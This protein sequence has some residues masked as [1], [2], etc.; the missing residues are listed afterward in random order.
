MAVRRGQLQP[1]VFLAPLQ[2]KNMRI[3]RNPKQQSNSIAS[4]PRCPRPDN[5]GIGGELSPEFGGGINS[6]IGG[7]LRRIC[8]AGMTGANWAVTNAVTSVVT[9]APDHG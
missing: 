1:R 7:R 9:N 8:Q 4:K 3:Y 2:F 5:P 6:G